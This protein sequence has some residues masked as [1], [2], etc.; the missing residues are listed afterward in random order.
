VGLLSHVRVPTKATAN[1]DDD[2]D[3]L[4]CMNGRSLADQQIMI[5]EGGV[6][7]AGGGKSG[8]PAPELRDL[9]KLPLRELSK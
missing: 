3:V 7:S 9:W 8:I 4:S 6:A 2:A 1:S 5:M